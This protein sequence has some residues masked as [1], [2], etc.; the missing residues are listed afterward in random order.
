MKKIILFTFLY[1]SGIALLIHLSPKNEK[2]ITAISS[3]KQK[4]ERFNGPSEFAKFHKAIRT[5]EGENEPRYTPGYKWRELSKAKSQGISA[6]KKTDNGVIEFTERGPS[7]VPGRTRGLLVDPDDAS[8]NTWFAGSAGGGVWKTTNGGNSWTLLTPDLPNLATTVL[9]MAASNHQVIY[10]GTGEGFFNLDAINGGGIFKSTNKGLTWTSL[11]NTLSFG[12]INRLVI[13]PVNENIVVAATSL[14]IYRSTDGGTSWLKVLD[15]SVIQDIKAD[16]SNFAIQYASQNGV[17]VWKS[18]DSGSTWTLSNAGMGS[19]GRVEL[20]VSPVN[21]NMIF[22]S[23]EESFGEGSKLLLSKN[24]GATWDQVSVEFNN[25]DV[26]F[27]GGQ[28]WYDNTIVCHPFNAN[29][30]Y[31]GGVSLF[32][33]ELQ[34]GSTNIDYYDAE[35]VDTDNFLSLVNFSANYYGGRLDVGDP[36]IANASVEVRFGPGKSQKAHRFLVPEGATSGVLAEDYTYTNYID[37][38]FE[39]WDIKNNRQLMISF[40]DQG[41]DGAFNLI[42]Q[43]TE[44]TTPAI[45]HSREYLF[46]HNINYNATTPSAS[47]TISGGHEVQQMYNI[48][49]VLAEGGVWDEDNLPLSTFRINQEV[50]Q[51]LNASTITSADVYAQFDGKNNFSNF[52]VDLHPDQ[53]N[54]V[55]IPISGSSFRLL[56]ANDGGV[57]I[58]NAS[59]TPAINEGDWTMVGNSYNTSQFYGADKRVGFDEYIGGMQDNGTWKSPKDEAAAASTNYLFNIGGDGFEVIWNNRDTQ[60]L[61]GGS[62][63]NGFRRSVNG[64][65]TWANA[66]NGLSGDAPFISKLA[67]SPALPD[68]IFALSSAGVFVSNNFGQSWSLTPITTKWGGGSLLDVEV[69]KANANIVWA[70]LGMTNSLALHVSID[71]GASFTPTTNFTTV[72]MGGITKLASH[73]LDD[74]TAYALFSLSGKPKILKTT[75]LGNTWSDISGFG[76]NSASATGFPDVAVYCLYVRPDNTDIIW[77]GTEIGIVESQDGG[78]TW[79]ILNDFPNVSVWDMKGVDDQIVIATHGRGIWTATISSTQSVLPK[80]PTFVRMGTNPSEKLSVLISSEEAFDSL[81]VYDGSTYAGTVKNLIVGETIIAI[82]ATPFGTK[83]ISGIAYRQG[84]PFITNSITGEHTD[85]KSSATSFSDYFTNLSNFKVLG[86][87]ST[88]FEEQGAKGRK[89]LHTTHNYAASADYTALLLVPITIASS[90]ATFKYRDVAIVEPANDQVVVEATLD[91]IHWSPIAPA[92]SASRNSSWLTTYTNGAK[93]TYAQL[94]DQE[95][96]LLTSLSAGDKALFRFRLTANT[97]TQ[98][99]GWAIDFVAIQEEP[100]EAEYT[101]TALSAPEVFPNPTQVDPTVRYTLHKKTDVSIELMNTLGQK[102]LVKQH[103]QL[104]VGDHSEKISISTLFKGTYL[105]VL[106]TEENSQTVRLVID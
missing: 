85:L 84:A 16:P 77:V 5:A 95:I 59:A 92:Y 99:W 54:L 91:G 39:V 83:T 3:I 12:D 63:G 90:N 30:I 31:F 74:E 4:K 41:R 11:T 13:S 21:V 104:S 46:V 52:G 60:L 100:T 34:A 42:T 67:N 8:K 101:N 69:S 61:I 75:N 56:N 38:P 68:R 35:E 80:V 33:L 43:N 79:N 10:M 102:L 89:T 98:A 72:S 57:F 15:E 65:T 88:V 105:I 17:G 87:Q 50:K 20:A 24:A 47:V 96:N 9:A 64:G 97:N 70:G 44:A 55:V 58:S 36:A 86:F 73:P 103:K 32:R 78:A 76:T 25:Q 106:R 81:Q 7:N 82:N 2:A 93:G 6:R 14:G 26:D 27:L 28:G 19:V 1:A 66:T 62:Q 71:G 94:I 48:W 29:L 23:A 37:V 22:A 40:R 49:P 51:L 18:T 53:H 45:E